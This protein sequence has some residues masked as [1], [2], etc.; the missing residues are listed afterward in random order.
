MKL[1]HIKL[2]SVIGLFSIIQSGYSEEPATPKTLQNTKSAFL[3][4]IYSARN[5]EINETNH[6]K[7]NTPTDLLNDRDYLP[8][9]NYDRSPDGRAANDRLYDRGGRDRD[10]YHRE[11][12]SSRDYRKE[13]SLDQ[14]THLQEGRHLESDR[15][16][17]PRQKHW[18]QDNHR[19]GDYHHSERGHVVDEIRHDTKI[20]RSD[21]RL[22]DKRNSYDMLKGTNKYEVNERRRSGEMFDKDRRHHHHNRHDSEGRVMDKPFVI[23]INSDCGGPSKGR[24][25]HKFVI[26]PQCQPQCQ[27]QPHNPNPQQHNPYKSLPYQSPSNSYM[28]RQTVGSS[29]YYI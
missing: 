5:A 9:R 29:L 7:R 3:Q 23:N 16:S 8:P 24:F 17:D 19:G 4:K 2:L 20:Y 13:E 15:Y 25:V 26:K 28:S 12:D 10:S 6:T 27:P 11:L 1:F 18:P 14:K 21:E 22:D